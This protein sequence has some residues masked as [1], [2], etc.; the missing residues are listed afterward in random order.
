M[1]VNQAL[2]GRIKSKDG[3]GLGGNSSVPYTV[4]R[5]FCFYTMFIFWIGL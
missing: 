5:Y 3:G 1:L 4:K 2:L